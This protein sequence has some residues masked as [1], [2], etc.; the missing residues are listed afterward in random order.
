MLSKR[1]TKIEL[2]KV[3]SFGRL[4]DALQQLLSLFSPLPAILQHRFLNTISKTLINIF[5]DSPLPH[6]RM[7]DHQQID[8]QTVKNHAQWTHEIGQI[9]HPL[10]H[11]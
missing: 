3:V 7:H 6:N 9:V 4:L 5:L 1:I 8:D 2:K 10:I 11:L